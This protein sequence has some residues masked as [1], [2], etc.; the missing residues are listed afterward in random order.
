MKSEKYCVNDECNSLSND[1]I[2]PSSLLLLPDTRC[3]RLGARVAA[4]SLVRCAREICIRF[5]D[6]SAN[7]I[8]IS[9][10][11]D[12]R[13]RNRRAMIEPAQVATF[14]SHDATALHRPLLS[15]AYLNRTR[16]Q[17]S[18]NNQ[19]NNCCL[20]SI[21]TSGKHGPASL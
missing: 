3:A 19:S 1:S 15:P 11:Y 7:I 21:H 4:A 12:N 9:Q 16:R 14:V 17:Q 6:N 10:K 2:S 20:L 18:R 5:R 13:I 8:S